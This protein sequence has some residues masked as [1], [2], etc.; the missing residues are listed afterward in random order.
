MT[1]LEL[2]TTRKIVVMAVLELVMT[3][4]IVMTTVSELMPSA[5]ELV[6]SVCKPVSSALE[7]VP[8]VFKL[9]PTRKNRMLAFPL[10][11][12]RPLEGRGSGATSCRNVLRTKNPGVSEG[13][14]GASP[15]S[16]GFSYPWDQR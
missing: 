8:T 14:C 16:H 9:V 2:L 13:L 5:L 11:F 1:V 12:P 4:K 10:L 3:R 15:R 7:L 6:S